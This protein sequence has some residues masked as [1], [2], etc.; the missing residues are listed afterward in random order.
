MKYTNKIVLIGLLIALFIANLNSQ[1][2]QTSAERMQEW[3]KHLASDQL[4]G[5]FPGTE[6]ANLAADYIEQYFKNI[7]LKAY[8]N[9]YRQQMEVTTSVSATEKNNVSFDQLIE[10]LGIPESEWRTMKQNWSNGK[11]YVPL[12]FSD[13]GSCSGDIVFA[14]FGITASELNYD[15]Y[16]DVD[17][18]GKIVVVLSNTPDGESD[19]GDFSFYSSLRYKASNAAKKGAV[20]MILVKIQGDSMNVFERLEYSNIGKNSGIIA[21]QAHRQSISKFFAKDKQLV[22][23]EQQIMKTKKP[24]SYQLPRVKGNITVDL[25]DNQVP[26]YNI[27]GIVEGTDSKLKDEHIVIG[28]H[29]DHLGWGGYNSLYRGK[30]AMVHNGA[31]D[32]A[33]GVAAMME[34][35]TEIAKNPLKRSVIFV[36][37]TAEEMGLLG[38]EHFVRNS[39]VALEKVVA[40]LNL[41]M[42]GR[43]KKDEF[44]V[45]GSTSSANFPTLLDSVALLDT[46]KVIKASDAFAPSDH[47][48]FYK[49]NIPVFMFN[50]GVHEDYHR[51]SDDWDKLNYKGMAKIVSFITKVTNS[52]GNED[53]RPEFIKSTS[54]ENP[55]GGSGGGRN[56]SKVW[57]GIIPNFE[58]SP[59][60]CKISGASPG[61]PAEKAGMKDG[62]IITKMNDIKVKNL[63]DFMYN[64][65]D[66]KAG[67]VV[68]VEVLRGKNYEEKVMM[69]VTLVDKK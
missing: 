22:I 65:K 45:F 20:G 38:S 52:I 61:S 55:R 64:L 34:I 9:S 39:P 11:E 5:R 12:A 53:A 68:D 17:V 58:E 59:L 35:A 6:G 10:R 30:K 57:F 37:F 8:A 26:T 36:A 24:A 69:K 15:D 49:K 31:D 4:Q 27:F 51:P 18:K 42:V 46:V 2:A 43:M 29:Y 23:L 7:G 54:T 21:I 56:S 47:A 33:S 32:N 40:M 1:T 13:N 60:G 67:D 63:H 66:F 28:A 14:G 25:V 62:D 41:D 48:S 19:K 16:K 3:V 44:T 50:S